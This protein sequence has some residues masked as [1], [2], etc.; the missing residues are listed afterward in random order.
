MVRSNHKTKMK[1]FEKHTRFP[2]KKLKGKNIGSV[3]S[4]Y[5]SS[6]DWFRKQ[7]TQKTIQKKQWTPNPKN[8]RAASQRDPTKLE[9]VESFVLSQNIA[10][11]A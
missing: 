8:N 9:V 6:R 2:P 4:Y 10:T 3:R 7:W 1:N 11:Q 5:N